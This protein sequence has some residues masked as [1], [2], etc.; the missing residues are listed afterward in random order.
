LIQLNPQINTILEIGTW[1]GLG[2]TL[3]FLL[4]LKENTH[5][6]FISLE[7]N[8][9][10]NKIAIE[11][12]R[13][14]LNP[15][16]HN[17]VWG[18]ILTIDELNQIPLIFPECVSNPEFYRW[19]T[20]DIENVVI[21][22][23]VCH[24]LPETIEF[25]LFDGGEFTTYREFHKLFPRCS[26]YIALDDVN[27]SKCFHIRSYLRNHGDWKEIFFTNDFNGFSIFEKNE[28]IQLV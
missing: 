2:S 15:T 21:A 9:E 3:C 23:N 25:V 13:D 26:R 8:E 19:H 6:R 10:K 20:V 27:V 12:T 24:I 1:N 11:N 17:I 4:A 5:T 28:T 18:S 16:L 22:P 7:C 14:M